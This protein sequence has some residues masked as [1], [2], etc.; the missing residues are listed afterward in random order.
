MKSGKKILVVEDEVIT[1]LDIQRR[2]KSLGYIVPETVSSGEEAIKKVKEENPDLVLMDINLT[3]EMDGIE[4]ASNIHSFSDIP[5]IY[6]TAFSDENILE[7]AKIT[8]PYGYIVKPLKDRELQIILEIAFYK[9][10][11][12]KKLS[13]KNQWLAAVI[14]SI[15]DALIATDP[16]G[17]IRLIN[18]IAEALTGWKQD[19]ALGTPLANVFNIISENIDEQ[20]EDPITKATRDGMFYGLAERTILITKEGL[21]R[22]V[23][24]IGSTIKIEGNKIIGIVF[25]FDDITW[26]T[27]IDDM[28]KK[29]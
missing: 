24:I 11:M 27:R 23:D 21:K 25:V 3:D 29:S 22:Y 19:E 15:G 1:A 2:L 14:E 13:E 26:R 16:E 20:I 17:T 8:E 9:H 7:R 28:L 12:E 18:P 10:A 4:A 6:L 5:V